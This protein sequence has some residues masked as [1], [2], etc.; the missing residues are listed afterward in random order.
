MTHIKISKGLDIP[1]KG[2]PEGEV[3]TLKASGESTSV[4]PQQIALNLTPFSNIKFKVLVKQGESVKIGQPLVEDRDV[5][6]RM[7]CAPAS[8]VIK[9]IQRGH[10]RVIT[11][12][13]IDVEKNEEHHSSQ[14]MNVENSSREQII[15]ALKQ[16]GI[17]SRI[18]TRPFNLVADPTKMPRTIFVRAIESA[19]L[20]PPAEIQVEGHEEDFQ[21]G[22][23][24]LR[25][26]TDGS[27]NLVYRQGTPCTAFTQAKNVTHHTAEGPH[28]IGN[29]S[30]HIDRIDPIKSA[31]EIIWTLNV[32]DV[33]TLG[34]FVR[35]GHYY[36]DRVVSIAGPGFLED[37]IGYY[38]VREGMPVSALISG[39]LPGEQTARLISGDPL[40][41]SK[42][43]SDGF[44]GFNHFALCAIPENEDREFLHFFR[45]GKDKYS[46]S[47]AYL[48]GHLD[49]SKRTYDFTTSLHGEH[50]AFI[51]STLYD[52]VM[53]LPISTMLLVKAVMA[54]D[55]DLAAELGLITVDSEDFALPTFVCQSKMEMTEIMKAGLNQY[56]HDTLTG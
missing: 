41:G 1:I 22:L 27:V 28:P 6:G 50:R 5:P 7:F 38:K 9:D 2:K 25:K 42:V 13:V 32:H 55:Y 23:D 4:I 15:E 34:H 47:K 19:P 44:L 17:F 3:Q 43:E 31:E 16:G 24:T 51:D 52:E 33:I 18:R 20:V 26:L 49:N 39:R 30:V 36:V 37:R 12:I 14:K 35:T 21:I 54:E 46:F 29:V 8:G 56:A 53:P 10:R 48:S 45:L 11:N 40:M